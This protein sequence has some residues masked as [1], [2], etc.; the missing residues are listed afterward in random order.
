MKIES[1]SSVNAL[2][3]S[4]LLCSNKLVDDSILASHIITEEFRANLETRRA[5][6]VQQ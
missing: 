1:R 3:C 4:V 2:Y 5:S 6:S